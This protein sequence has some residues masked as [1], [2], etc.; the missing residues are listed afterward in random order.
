[1]GRGVLIGCCLL[2]S[3][4]LPTGDALAA[5]DVLLKHASDGTLVVVG[6]GWRHDQQ[7]VVSLGQRRFPVRANT[8][9]EFEL[10]T[11]LAAY[12]GAVSIQHAAAPD[13][14]F[15]ALPTAMPNPLAVLLAWSVAEGSALLG[16]VA[17]VWLVAV[18][19][20]RRLRAGGYPR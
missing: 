3:L 20:A 5:S 9:G 8:S 12:H 7:L 14:G 16:I 11:G 1:M 10:E 17:G 15:M 6:T 4:S 13:L 2:L 18:G 19:V